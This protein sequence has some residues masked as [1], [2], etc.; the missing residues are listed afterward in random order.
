MNYTTEHIADFFQSVQSFSRKLLSKKI[1]QEQDAFRNLKT[2]YQE[3]KP[4]LDTLRKSEAPFFN[5][6]HIL[7]I[8]HLEEALHT[9]FLCELLNP[10]GSHGQGALYLD[11]F[12]NKVMDSSLNFKDIRNFSIHEELPSVFGRLD[13][14]LSFNIKDT[15]KLIV[16]ENKIY[17]GDQKD[18]MERYYNYA[19]TRLSNDSDL[20]LLY[21][22][23][24]GKMLSEFSMNAKL[25]TN[26]R[27]KNALREISYHEHI[28]P[29]LESVLVG[30]S[31]QK[32]KQTIL[33][34]LSTLYQL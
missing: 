27:S 4:K 12:F 23:P 20:L 3:V 2:K 16:I 30:T 10:K 5:L 18:Q 15:R 31:S 1:S 6:F 33:Q 24:R 34:Y 29:W 22:T 13:I 9:P 19:N 25:Q 17:A 32:V 28:V 11:A 7:N 8:Q 14:L 26:L 21:L